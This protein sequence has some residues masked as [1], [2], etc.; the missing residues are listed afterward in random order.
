MPRCG[1]EEA[2]SPPGLTREMHQTRVK[3][4]TLGNTSVLDGNVL[5][6]LD[7]FLCI[8]LLLTWC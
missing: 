5:L 3:A 7:I 8:R 1:Q 4:G 6:F 2:E